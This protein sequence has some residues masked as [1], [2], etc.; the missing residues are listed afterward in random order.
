MLKMFVLA[1]HQCFDF[2]INFGFHGFVFFSKRG[3]T[4][5]F[6][7][8]KKPGPGCSKLTTS[9]VNETLNYFQTLSQIFQYFC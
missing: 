3:I 8:H 1:F 5:I 6:G 7:D 4:M 9:L 2:T